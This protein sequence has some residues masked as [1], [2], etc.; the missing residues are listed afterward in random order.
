[1]AFQ[2][3]S[4]LTTTAHTKTTVSQT[5]STRKSESTARS[6]NTDFD[7]NALIDA[8]QALSKEIVLDKLME[9]LMKVVIVNA[10]AD[11]AFLILFE[12]KKSL[13]YSQFHLNEKYTPL[14][15]PIPV[16]EKKEEMCLAIVKYVTKTQTELLLNNAVDEGNFRYDPYILSKKPKSILCIPLMQKGTLQGAL[17]LE[18][19]A[20]KGVFTSKRMRLLTLLSS[21]MA[22]AIENAQ[23][24]GKLELKVIERTKE[25]Q[26]RN[27][28]LQHALQ[29]IKNVQQQMI[30][31]EKL[32]SLGL[33]TS[34]IAH[35]L[36]NPLNFVINFSQIAHEYVQ[37]LTKELQEK[38][39]LKEDKLIDLSE[40]AEAIAKV[41]IHGKRADGIIKGMLMHAHQSASKPEKVNLN[42]LLDQAVNLTY[43][44]YRKKDTRFNLTINKNFD[45]HLPEIEGFPGDLLRVFINIIDNACYSLLDKTIKNPTDFSPTFDIRT[46]RS[47]GYAHVILRDNGLGI[48]K[49]IREKIFEPFF[50]TKPAGSG[51][52]LGLSI[53]Y[54]IITK[55]HGGMIATQSDSNSFTEF[56]LSFP[57][58]TE[59]S[60]STN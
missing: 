38:H 23:F 56:E 42:T 60:F 57:L 24:Y 19:T 51:T 40:L 29:T 46:F 14:I 47:D 53:V 6:L 9:S 17:Y 5:A 7:V 31:Q 15:S 54:D 41:D 26:Q 1:M 22:I 33:L 13:V 34:G 49:E 2:D 45:P 25:L 43:H 21:Q 10:G 11:K 52:G 44:S 30:Q 35:E 58:T 36:K 20:T 50:T 27:Q 55:Q 16:D 48:P 32:A 28:E 12:N 8:S 59:L 37:D 18:N 39:E 4:F 3:L